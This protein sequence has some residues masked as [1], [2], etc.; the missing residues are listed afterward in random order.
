M[1]DFLKDERY[2]EDYLSWVD[3]S[4]QKFQLAIE[5]VAQAR[6]AD[7]PGIHNG[8][9]ILYNRYLK[10]LR[11]LYSAGR[12]IQ[13]I[14]ALMPPLI[15]SMEKTWNGR[16]VEQ[17]LWVV[18]VGVMLELENGLFSRLVNLVRKHELHDPVIE[19]L[20]EGSAVEGSATAPYDRLLDVIRSNNQHEQ[21]QKIKEY[22]E[23]H[24]YDGNRQAGWH[25]THNH[26]DAIYC[27]YWS[28]ESGAVVK[29]LGIN[30]NSMKDA[31]YYPYDLVHYRN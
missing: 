26:R 1:R 7:D 12:P 23:L 2:F 28:F 13:E 6:G 31:P 25:D 30:D 9:S 21:L 8:Y 22:L 17:M 18:S 5:Q 29:V 19:F 15:D 20:I 27:G 4:I 16:D 14:E 24:W 11:A 10:K 3:D